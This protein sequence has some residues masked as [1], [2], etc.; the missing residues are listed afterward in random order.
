MDAATAEL[1]WGGAFAIWAL[2]L[3]RPLA[4]QAPRGGIH[5]MKQAAH[6]DPKIVGIQLDLKGVMFKPRYIPTLLADLAERGINTV[7]IEYEDAFPFR[8][9]DV[10]ADPATAWSRAT[11]ARFQRVAREHGIDVIPLQQCLGHLEYVFRWDRYRALA[12]DRAYPSTLRLGSRKG[13]ALIREMLGQVI[14]AHPGSRYINLGMDEAHGLA[15]AARRAGRPV[16]ELYVEYLRELC[17]FVAPTGKTPIIWADMLQD[18]FEHGRMDEFRDRVVLGTWD[19]VSTRADTPFIRLGGQRVSRAWLDRPDDPRAPAIGPDTRFVEDLPPALQTLIEPYRRGDNFEP[20]AMEQF[21]TR[22]GFRCIGQTTVRFSA[23]GAVL[24]DYNRLFDTITGYAE[25]VT[26]A[27]QLGLIGTSWARGTTFCPPNF[28]I[29]LTWPSID[30][31]ARRMGKRPKPFWPGV[32]AAAVTR[33]ITQLGRCATTWRLEEPL[34]DDWRR[35]GRRVTRHRFEWRSL[36]LMARVL[37]LHRRSEFAQLEVDYF[38]ANTRP[39][40]SEWQRRMRDARGIL[41][42]LLALRRTVRAHFSKRYHGAAFAEWL[43]DLFDLHEARLRA[44]LRT[45]GIKLPVARAAYT[46]TPRTR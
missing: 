16:L 27:G 7:L 5:F 15:L 28:N 30:H 44:C 2:T 8:G 29:D 23:L 20:F 10:A 40:D 19:Y 13:R 32:P 14:E 3:G 41:K 36:E 17:E 12:E 45:S 21:W 38:H 24:P 46:G 4:A 43:A 39:V 1:T 22:Q 6:A 42:D 18:H 11:V 25:A 31:L 26:R 9:I 34:A 35:L 33:L 37:R